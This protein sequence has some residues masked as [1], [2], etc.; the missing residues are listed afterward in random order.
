MSEKKDLT[1]KI[2]KKADG[3]IAHYCMNKLHNIDGPAL[4]PEGD[5]KKAEYYLFGIKHSKEQWNVKK[6]SMVG[7][8]WYKTSSGKA[9]G[10]RV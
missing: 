1:T 7:D 5:M 6:K 4:I 9:S 2:L 8:P 10:A 3:T